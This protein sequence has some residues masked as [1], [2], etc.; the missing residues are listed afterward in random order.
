LPGCP[1]VTSSTAELRRHRRAVHDEETG[2]LTCKA[3]GFTTA[4]HSDLLMHIRQHNGR[5]G[6]A[7]RNSARAPE[8]AA[9]DGSLGASD[10]SCL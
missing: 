8:E 3:C 4:S 5:K 1:Y 2:A 7:A 10:P 9:P 6:A